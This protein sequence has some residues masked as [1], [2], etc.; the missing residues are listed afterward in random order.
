MRTTLKRGMGRG[1]AVN[2]HARPV[3]PPGALSPISI[4]R[5]PEPPRRSRWATARA[6]LGWVLVALVVAAGSAAGGAYLWFHQSVAAVVAKT[7]DV[8][9]AAKRL[10]IALP[11]KPA[12]ALVVGY[13]QRA[14]EQKGMQSRSDTIMLVR[15][16]PETKSIS[17]LSFPRDLFVEIHCPGKPPFNSRINAAYGECGSKGTLETVR[18]LTGVPINYLITVNFRGFRQIVDRLGGVWLDV[19]RRY[20]NVND[21]RESTNFSNI[22]LQPGYQ[23]LSGTNALAFVRFRHTDD[24]YHR[25]ARQ[26]QFVRAFKEQV[27]Q[28]RPGVR[29]LLGIVSVIT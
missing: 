3:L 20:Y 4:Y 19:D 17:L 22:D 9:V 26:Q 13:D 10:D 28:Q 1:A 8:K 12:T 5:Q 14:G 2:G 11:G 21:G 7:P 18:K 23:K 16:D 15:A 6:V 29:T 27:S 24:D 25:L